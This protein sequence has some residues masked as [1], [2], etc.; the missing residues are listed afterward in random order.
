M[1]A[2]L[3]S[4][5]RYVGTVVMVKPR[6]GEPTKAKIKFDLHPKNKYDK[7]YVSDMFYALYEYA[8]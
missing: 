1:N 8:I 7:W 6:E 3:D 4:C 5:D 2:L